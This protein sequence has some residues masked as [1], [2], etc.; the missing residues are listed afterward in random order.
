MASCK[1]SLLLHPP[2]PPPPLLHSF[3]FPVRSQEYRSIHVA[4]Q[5]CVFCFELPIK[6]AG[7]NF[8]WRGVIFLRGFWFGLV[9]TWRTMMETNEGSLAEPNMAPICAL[10]IRNRDVDWVLRACMHSFLFFFFLLTIFQKL[11]FSGLL[12]LSFL[13]FFWSMSLC[14]RCL[15]LQKN[16]CH[17]SFA[18]SEIS[19]DCMD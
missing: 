16:R 3:A 19:R 5:I 14:D 9:W 7:A 12:S 18:V 4:F 17:Y 11:C 1:L 6:I 8:S 15:F 10:M 13:F 2:P